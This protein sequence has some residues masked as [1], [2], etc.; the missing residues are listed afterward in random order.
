MA[1]DADN[2]FSFDFLTHSS[3]QLIRQMIQIPNVVSARENWAISLY[4]KGF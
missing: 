4:V 2:T 3:N 1:L